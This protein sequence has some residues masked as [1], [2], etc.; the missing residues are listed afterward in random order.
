MLIVRLGHTLTYSHGNGSPKRMTNPVT[1]LIHIAIKAHLRSDTDFPRSVNAAKIEDARIEQA[2]TIRNRPMANGS[3][4]LIL[5]QMNAIGPRLERPT[6]NQ[7]KA[8]VL[9]TAGSFKPSATS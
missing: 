4:L 2:E 6:L 1:V 9:L 8:E 5:N 3:L 7:D